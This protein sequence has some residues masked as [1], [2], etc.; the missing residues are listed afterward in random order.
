MQTNVVTTSS[1]TTF[2][3]DSN[4]LVTMGARECSV[5]SFLII[6]CL[7]KN[8]RDSTFLTDTLTSIMHQLSVSLN[9]LSDGGGA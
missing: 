1:K 8:Q 7:H 2:L 4:L 6:Q 9:P 3:L 5:C